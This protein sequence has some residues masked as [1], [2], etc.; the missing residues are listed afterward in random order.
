MLHKYIRLLFSIIHKSICVEDALLFGKV[1]VNTLQQNTCKFCTEVWYIL[2]LDLIAKRSKW[3]NLWLGRSIVKLIFQSCPH[4]H[5]DFLMKFSCK[6]FIFSWCQSVLV[7]QPEG[8]AFLFFSKWVQDVLNLH[9]G[10]FSWI[11]KFLSKEYKCTNMRV[12]ILFLARKS[13]EK[14][15]NVCFSN[16]SFITCSYK[17][18]ISP[19]WLK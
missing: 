12:C 2:T 8:I 4:L 14:F 19:S 16:G 18:I 3:K 13:H 1:L 15:L 17:K 11:L 9:L 6:L 7:N 5:R 10:D